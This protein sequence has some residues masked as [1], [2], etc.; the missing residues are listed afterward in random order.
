MYV[1]SHDWAPPDQLTYAL[2]SSALVLTEAGA[3]DRNATLTAVAGF[4]KSV[5]AE[6]EKS[7][8]ALELGE[9][10][11]L[12][13]NLVRTGHRIIGHLLPAL[14]GARRAIVDSTFSWNVSDPSP[15]AATLS[16]T[17][18]ATITE[19]LS[20][21]WDV[22][23]EG[24]RLAIATLQQYES[25]SKGLSAG[26]VVYGALEC[27]QSYWTGALTSRNEAGPGWRALLSGKA[28][29]VH[30]GEHAQT[31]MA[32]AFKT[33]S[34]TLL[35]LQKTDDQVPTDAYS[36]DILLSS[37]VSR[38]NGCS[39]QRRADL[40]FCTETRDCLEHRLWFHESPPH[41]YPRRF[42]QPS[43]DRRG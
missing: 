23:T 4:Q 24:G 18:V 5:L 13:L 8:G 16:T 38:S 39:G 1:A 25:S 34:Q 35:L 32:G 6:V 21:D 9:E 2:V 12:R 31:S 29:S 41:F 36:F 7:A 17:L 19:A 22:G 26:L 3:G 30:G 15:A 33:W 43:C 37:L 28:L 14:N 20:Q 10:R 40:V 11:V 42:A 27:R